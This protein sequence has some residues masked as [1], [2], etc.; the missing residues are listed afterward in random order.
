MIDMAVGKDTHVPQNDPESAETAAARRLTDAL[1]PS[2]IDAL[3]ADAKAADTPIDDVDGLLNP[4][5]QG[6]RDPRGPAPRPGGGAVGRYRH[7]RPC[8]LR[9]D[10]DS[11]GHYN[12]P[13]VFTFTVDERPRSVVTFTGTTPGS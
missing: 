12:R 6:R 5:D 4:D 3:L 10:F 13:D 9:F 1:A 7:R 11:A 8:A 2:A